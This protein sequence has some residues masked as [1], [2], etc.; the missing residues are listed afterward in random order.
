MSR[1]RHAECEGAPAASP[2][3]PVLAHEAEDFE[4]QVGG[5][6]GGVA[7]RVEGR[8]DF[9]DVAADDIDLSPAYGRD[10]VTVSVHQAAELPSDKL[11][12][13]TQAVFANHGGRPHWGKFHTQSAETLRDLHP[14][15]NHF[16]EIREQLDPTKRF[17]NP[18]LC[19][20]LGI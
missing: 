11:F 18:Y 10:T 8:R 2:R 1:Q 12:A 17:A 20:L 9:V 4:H 7:G 15:W 5:V 3:R 14:G 6:E 19:S 13:D 16:L